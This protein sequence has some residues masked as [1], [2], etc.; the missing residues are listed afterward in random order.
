MFVG[1]ECGFFEFLAGWLLIIVIWKI[2]STNNHKRL[3][4]RLKEQSRKETMEAL[5]YIG[6]AEAERNKRIHNGG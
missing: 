2:I 5:D 6:R 1:F 3:E 4:K